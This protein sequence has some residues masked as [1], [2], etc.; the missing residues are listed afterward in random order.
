MK[1][2]QRIVSGFPVLSNFPETSFC[3]SFHI[4]CASGLGNHLYDFGLAIALQDL[5]H[6]A[7]VNLWCSSQYLAIAKRLKNIKI[8]S[9][10]TKIKQDS[11]FEI[12]IDWKF[13]NQVVK[14]KISSSIRQGTPSFL[15]SSPF[16]PD[17]T[18][19]FL[20]ETAWEFPLRLLRGNDSLK[21]YVR[22]HF[23][24]DESDR[25]AAISFLGENGL[26]GKPYVVMAPH[27]VP[28]KAWGLEA[29]YSLANKVVSDFGVRTVFLG[30]SDSPK[31]E[32]TGAVQ[33]YGIPIPL[34]AALI[35][36][37]E[38]FIG[39]DSGLTHMALSF[40]KP[41]ITIFV[42]QKVPPIFV[43]SPCQ[44]N[45]PFVGSYLGLKKEKDIETLLSWT[46]YN[47]NKNDLYKAS[48]NCPGCLQKIDYLVQSLKNFSIWICQCGTAV[49]IPDIAMPT[50]SILKNQNTNLSNFPQ[51]IEELNLFSS[52]L[53]AELPQY[54]STSIR[55]P[56]SL[57]D[58]PFEEFFLNNPDCDFIGSWEGIFLFME[59]NGYFPISL[60]WKKENYFWQGEVHFS[61]IKSQ[62][63]LFL[64]V[65]GKIIRIP[66][67]DIAM[68]YY[69]G[70]NWVSY[71]YFSKQWKILM[72]WGH[73]EKAKRM[74][75][76]T[77]RISPSL[78]NLRNIFRCYFSGIIR[79]K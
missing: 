32:V 52:K 63:P 33:P 41:T 24:M 60:S 78:V 53:S 76:E 45:T 66:S 77:F 25:V 57:K 26:L 47:L 9:Y 62:K 72:T 37:S 38:V 67:Y 6:K 12:E 39:H 2:D 65:F 48:L 30:F 11:H 23:P 59:K 10:P 49:K 28:G 19:T 68:Y 7:E 42:D 34:I 54:F 46:G 22:P 27:V 56:Y 13:I 18:Q 29:F 50:L 14:E 16:F 75:L 3:G 20:Q 21:S 4:I 74:A 40:S 31:L 51:K 73:F 55:I 43:R 71:D 64:P 1:K 35:E 61:S 79:I 58:F 36:K 15:I 5:F 69:R 17:G 44:E 70:I 8:E